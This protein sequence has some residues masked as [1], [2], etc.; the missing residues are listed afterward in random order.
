MDVVTLKGWVSWR[1]GKGQSDMSSNPNLEFMYTITIPNRRQMRNIY[2]TNYIIHTQLH[3]H[4]QKIHGTCTCANKKD[5]HSELSHLWA[6]E[7]S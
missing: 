6:V 3:A 4:I 2:A 5:T 7:G 1:S